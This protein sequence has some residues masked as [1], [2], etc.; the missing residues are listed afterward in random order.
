MRLRA[1][2]LGLLASSCSSSLLYLCHWHKSIKLWW[3]LY[4]R[5]EKRWDNTCVMCFEK[6]SA[7][8]SSIIPPSWPTYSHL[9]DSYPPPS[10]LAFLLAYRN[11][12]I[13]YYTS[14]TL[15]IDR[16]TSAKQKFFNLCCLKYTWIDYMMGL[17]V[18]WNPITYVVVQSDSVINSTI[19]LN[20]RVIL[21]DSFNLVKYL[22]DY[23]TTIWV[24]KDRIHECW[25]CVFL[26]ELHTSLHRLLNYPSTWY[27]FPTLLPW[28]CIRWLG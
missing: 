15:H 21:F 11:S 9:S 28:I 3:R 20:L 5:S 13:G 6:H 10:I 19:I 24:F 7:I 27:N 2:G 8:V 12:S 17:A 26:G 16:I 25:R 18:N 23:T 4:Q 22:A 1:E 14:R